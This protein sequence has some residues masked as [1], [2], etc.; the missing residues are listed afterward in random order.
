MLKSVILCL[1]TYIRGQISVASGLSGGG[2]ISVHGSLIS[3]HTQIRP[4]VMVL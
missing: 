4:E 2:S 3:L 1:K